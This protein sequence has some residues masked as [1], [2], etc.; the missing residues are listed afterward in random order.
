MFDMNLYV[1]MPITAWMFYTSQNNDKKTFDTP[2]DENEFE[3]I[4]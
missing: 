3:V 4:A 2:I 1:L